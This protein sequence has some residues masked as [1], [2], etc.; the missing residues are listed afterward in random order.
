MTDYLV[1]REDGKLEVALFDQY[2]EEDLLLRSFVP[3]KDLVVISEVVAER[4]DEEAKRQAHM[5]FR[6]EYQ[7][8]KRI[9]CWAAGALK[10]QACLRS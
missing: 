10:R 5:Y 4:P 2:R 9:D 8:P 1:Y 3:G 6:G 7:D